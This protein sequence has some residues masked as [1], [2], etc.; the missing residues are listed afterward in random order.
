MVLGG[1]ILGRLLGFDEVTR[2]EAN[3]YKKRKRLDHELFLVK[4]IKRQPTEASR[5]VLTRIQLYWHPGLRLL[6]LLNFQ[7]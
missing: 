3:P 2:V 5:R 7:K 4:T 6:S 1:G